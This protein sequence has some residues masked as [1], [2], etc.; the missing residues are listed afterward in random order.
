[1]AGREE[2]A[3]RTLAFEMNLRGGDLGNVEQREGT[4]KMCDGK[5]EADPEYSKCFTSQASRLRHRRT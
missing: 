3:P 2:L 5:S 1:M 4:L